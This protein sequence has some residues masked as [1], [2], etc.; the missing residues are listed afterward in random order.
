[1]EFH[2][3]NEISLWYD[4][5]QWSISLSG[6][7]TDQT[8]RIER[9]PI[10]FAFIALVSGYSRT[11]YLKGIQILSNWVFIFIYFTAA[12]FA[13]TNVGCDRL[14]SPSALWTLVI[15]EALPGVA[16][17]AEEGGARLVRS[18]GLGSWIG[19]QVGHSGL[20]GPLLFLPPRRTLARTVLGTHVELTVHPLHQGLVLVYEQFYSISANGE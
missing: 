16:E 15:S 1:M 19:V 13:K 7:L 10:P 6:Q 11:I 8:C 14:L 2:Y 20:R 3:F 4:D 9:Q 18:S 17:L 5:K 12:Y